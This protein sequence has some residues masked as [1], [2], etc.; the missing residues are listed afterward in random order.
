M[1]NKLS[2]QNPWRRMDD[3]PSSITFYA[4]HLAK[5]SAHEF[6]L[7]TNN[8]RTMQYKESFSGFYI[9]NLITKKWK[10]WMKYPYPEWEK[11][12]SMQLLFDAKRNELYL[13]QQGFYHGL[14]RHMKSINIK[15]KRISD[16]IYLPT[17]YNDHMVDV[18]NTIH[19]IG[20]QVY[21]QA[22]FGAKYKIYNKDTHELLIN[23]ACD[24]LN[25]RCNSRTLCVFIEKS[26]KILLIGTSIWEY[27]VNSNTW[28][29]IDGIS[30]YSPC[31]EK[32]FAA[33]TNDDKYV[34]IVPKS[35]RSWRNNIFVMD[36]LDDG[37]YK[38]RESKIK[39]PQWTEGYRSKP[40][41]ICVLTGN[42]NDP[43]LVS[44]YIRMICKE[45]RL[46]VPSEIGRIVAVFYEREVLHCLRSWG[47]KENKN[48]HWCID[49]SLIVS[50]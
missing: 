11:A 26:A 6:I 17:G 3:P 29:V 43:I 33:V 1:G 37:G 28:K 35:D 27:S 5:L 36:I 39:L 31:E 2:K 41:Q 25:E 44:G 16:N 8:H 21:K 40:H 12:Y 19:L 30:F 18:K 10:L 14:T 32:G 4:G 34:I 50:E 24:D 42:E 49:V 45:C 38:L 47:Y 7:A 46:I 22:P 15:T 20:S 9:F 23:D 48:E 13:W